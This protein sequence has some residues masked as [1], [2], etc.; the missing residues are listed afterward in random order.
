M[1][2]DFRRV[3][4]LPRL[5]YVM[6]IR[7]GEA[8]AW[9]GT[10]VVVG[11]D[12][13]FDGVWSGDVG[14]GDFIDAERFGTGIRSNGAGLDLVTPRAPIDRIVLSSEGE[15]TWLSNSLPLLLGVLDD[16]LD[17]LS[18][19][20][21][22]RI[23]GRE[24]GLSIKPLVL[25]T[26]EGRELRV[27]FGEQGHIDS[28]GGLV[29][30]PMS[31]ASPFR[32]FEQYRDHL[33]EVVAKVV[34]NA[35]DARRPCKFPAVTLMSTGYDSTAVSALAKEAG[36]TEALT[37]RRYRPGT[38]ELV[39]HP[40]AIADALS[41]QLHE[42]ERGVWLE[43]SDLK[44]AQIAASGISLMSVPLLNMEAEISGRTILTGYSGD[45][46]WDPHNPR[47]YN[48]MATSTGIYS[49]RGEA[50]IR[51][52]S[53]WNVVPVPSISQSA[54]P[55]IAA[56]SNDGRML[57]WSV[58]GAYDRPIA[59]RIAEEAGVPREAFGN[60]K[61][62][63]SGRVGSGEL[64]RGGDR[65]EREAELAHLLSPEARE[66]FLDFVDVHERQGGFAARSQRVG[67]YLF[68]KVDAVDWRVGRRFHRYGL[69]GAVPRRV[70]L[71]LAVRYRL[72][73]D[74]TA[75]LPHW[76]TEVVIGQ[77]HLA[78]EHIWQDAAR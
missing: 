34:S 58:G 71:E 69:R 29:A 57:A 10:D 13:L 7:D 14:E 6:M 2:I 70:R 78:I 56:I 38:N 8:V 60:K 3:P 20:Y 67:H 76:G 45:A 68:N 37:M 49:G 42:V 74:Y 50:E 53:G 54:H 18:L 24:V 75:L 65:G 15:S 32:S 43:S 36:A 27:L 44:E 9:H 5:A 77:E 51:L 28:T 61:W 23:V 31:V 55:S 33:A 25:P 41:M 1:K 12:W 30:K 17:P 64:F 73:P 48:D 4:I 40:A 47:V 16:R 66:S 11:D 21:R 59:R 19:D 72:Y 63:A 26:A 22:N 62:A 35:D 39:D 52:R 46:I